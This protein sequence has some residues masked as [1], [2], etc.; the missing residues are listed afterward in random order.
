MVSGKQKKISLSPDQ[1]KKVEINETEDLTSHDKIKDKESAIHYTTIDTK[2]SNVEIENKKE[3]HLE[4][5]L[6]KE[7][8]LD[9]INANIPKLDLKPNHEQIAVTSILLP[10]EQNVTTLVKDTP[11]LSDLI[12]RSES[13]KLKESHIERE[14]FL[15]KLTADIQ[16]VQKVTT[17]EPEIITPSKLLQQNRNKYNLEYNCK[18]D[19]PPKER[20]TEFLEK[21]ILSNDKIQSIIQNLSLDKTDAPKV[22]EPEII[23]N[24]TLLCSE[25]KPVL[26]ISERAA[27][28]QDSIDEIANK[29]KDLNDGNLVI[30][31][32]PNKIREEV[33]QYVDIPPV[34]VKD[35]ATEKENEEQEKVQESNPLLKRLHK[36]SGFPGGLNF[37]SVIG[38]LKSKTRNANNSGLKPVFKKFDP[39][40]EISAQACSYF[41]KLL[42]YNFHYKFR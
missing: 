27:K 32:K 23:L 13:E 4:S 21:T 24:E 3:P 28:L 11:N 18:R 6:E 10:R 41:T 22:K 36:Q 39:D 7:K 31:S 37:G 26:S 12:I 5:Q 42:F 15:N 29:F 20:L 25:D 1:T 40:S 34:T 8:K 19:S 35:E 9:D 14:D 38:E 33:N 2:L 30:T 17:I 16:K